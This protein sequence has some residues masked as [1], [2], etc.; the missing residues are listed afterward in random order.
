MKK[1]TSFILM[2]TL[3]I[4][5]ISTTTSLRAGETT[6]VLIEKTFD[7][8]KSVKLVVRHE[9]GNVK[10]NNWDKDVISIKLTARTKTTDQE[11]AE[12]AFSRIR[13]D[14]HGDASEVYV[15]SKITNK[16][17]YNKHI[18]VSIDLE[19]FMPKS[20]SLDFENKFGN[21]FIEEVEGI[22]IVTSEY[23][24]ITIDALYAAES[25]VK[26]EFGSGKIGNFGGGN[27]SVSYG[28]L[29]LGSAGQVSVRSEYSDFTA[30]ELASIS[31]K[32]EGGNV[33]IGKVVSLKG[34][35]SFG[36]LEIDEL[37]NSIDIETAYGSLVVRHVDENFSD[38]N[39]VNEYG[40]AKLYIPDDATYHIEARTEFGSFKYQESLADFSYRVKSHNESTYKGII[41]KGSN[42]TS[43]VTVESS[44]GSVS[45]IT[46]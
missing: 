1:I 24:A 7:V 46:K 45:L 26:V 16:S 14:V 37:T 11:K 41:G 23:G 3:I 18:D 13:W 5:L 39:I 33:K 17:N 4:I 30:G 40:S 44:Y 43:K 19:I 22:A 31:L 21:A 15:E 25:R 8:G 32:A 10:C 28:K 35:S 36:N 12:K 42:P 2:P 29:A 20:I 27:L 34:T 9:H 6:K 38:L